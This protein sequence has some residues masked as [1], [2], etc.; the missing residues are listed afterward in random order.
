MSAADCSDG[1]RRLLR[2]E[3]VTALP[4]IDAAIGRLDA[5]L[6]AAGLPGLESPSDVTPIRALAEEVSPYVL[7]AELRRFWERVDPEGL[8]VY[9]FPLLRG[10]AHSLE[11]LRGLREL[12]QPPFGPPPVLLPL[13]YASHCYGVIE[14]GSEW[15]DGGT[16]FELEFDAVPVVAYSLADRVDLLAE[17]LFEGHF[18]RAGDDVTIDHQIEQE[19]RIARLE[20]AGPHAVYGELHA[21]PPE[22]ESWPAHWLAASGVDLRDRE[23][24]GATHSI[25]E[26]V[27]GAGHG[28]GRGRIHALVRSLV[29]W[30]EGALVGVED[31][32]GSL[33]V[34]CPSGTSPWGPVHQREFEF[35]VTVEG[36]APAVATDVRPLD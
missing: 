23:P 26:L 10:P 28:T 8:G 5:A 31:G 12:G 33:D 34:W 30:S 7:P 24:L 13:D 35:D 9:T 11:L 4:D 32:S 16:I 18:E 36:G 20:A 25:A 14:L 29:G 19:R 22:L 3:G 15:S 17:L 2:S 27:A 1:P 21:I 6:R